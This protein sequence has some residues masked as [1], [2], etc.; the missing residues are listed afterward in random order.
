[1]NGWRPGAPG[2]TN[3]A[4]RLSEL[5]MKTAEPP[6]IAELRGTMKAKLD[7][8]RRIAKTAEDADHG[9][10]PDEKQ[11]VNKLLD[12]ANTLKSKIDEKI[13]DAQMLGALHDF[14]RML[15]DP[16]GASALGK[17]V[18]FTGSDFTAH[19][20]KALTGGGMK[21][22]LAAGSTLVDTPIIAGPVRLG[23]PP[24]TVASV[25]TQIPAS[26][27]AFRYAR[28]TTRTNN[29]APVAPG[30]VKPT[31]MFTFESVDDKVRVV[32]HITEA[33]D[34]SLLDDAAQLANILELELRY[35]VAAAL[36]D[37]LVNG[38]GTAPNLPG[39]LNLSGTRSQAMNVDI[40]TTVHDAIMLL[41]DDGISASAILMNSGDWSLLET[42]RQGAQG[43]WLLGSPVGGPTLP[44]ASAT[45][46]LW[47]VP[48]V[49]S[50][51]MP[52]GTAIVGD[53]RG[54]AYL[55]VRE[56]TRID[57]SEN[58]SDDFARNQVRIRAEGRFGVAW[59][60]PRG[61]AVATIAGAS[62]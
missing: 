1:M 12:E 54:S 18:P 38:D 30:A 9:F 17:G 55:V 56:Q 3:T 8:A 14:S 39:L 45:R 11:R 29:A 53:F 5:G 41:A 21:A 60:R 24:L 52:V 2:D 49:L 48:V 26:G 40:A 58:V 6:E 4:T 23:E 36:D 57:V 7:E 37:Q 44:N 62:G 34:R 47:N 43:G 27:E 19:A 20:V 28:Q 22:A 33:L 15:V 31:S 51:A 59:V 61:F 10:T 32:A 16:S 25:F 13:G 50:S 46:Q 35:G 42:E